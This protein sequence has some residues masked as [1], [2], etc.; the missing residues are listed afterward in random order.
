MFA[1]GAAI[2]WRE[3]KPILGAAILFGAPM[4]ALLPLASIRAGALRGLHHIV[5]GQLSNTL[6]RPAAMAI[7]LFLLF[8]AGVAVGAP[9]AMALNSVTAIGGLALTQ[10]WLSRR[11]PEGRPMR[12]PE[13]ERGWLASSIPM[14]LTDAVQSLQLQ[15]SVLV[16]GIIAAPAQVGLFRVSL[17]ILPL[18]MVPTTVVNTVVLPTISKLHAEDDHTTLQKLVTATALTR[19]AGV[20]ILCLPFLFAAGPLLGLVFGP[21]YVAAADTIGIVAVGAIIGSAFGPNA[22]LLN[23]TGHER[24]VTRA[25]SMALAVNVTVIALLA[26]RWGSAGSAI[27]VLAGQCFWNVLLWM[28]AK[29]ALSIETSILGAFKR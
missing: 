7:L 8:S 23:M 2:A 18:V 11:L 1:I 21:G 16:L 19:F 4:I 17:A 20:S 25:V 27:G 15:L 26:P 9:E 28:D 5:L 14:A 29:R 24:R 12:S 22:A 10:Y 13:Q 3:G 6:L